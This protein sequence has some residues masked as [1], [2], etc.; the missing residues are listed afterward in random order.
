M[1]IFEEI[2]PASKLVPTLLQLCAEREWTKLGVLDLPRLPH[3]IHVPLVVSEVQP[4]NIQ[5]RSHG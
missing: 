2:R 5:A 4:S 1:T 3:E